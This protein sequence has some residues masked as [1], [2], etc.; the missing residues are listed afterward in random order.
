MIQ[1]ALLGI[2]LFPLLGAIANGVFGGKAGRSVVHAIA[3]L[4]VACSF[5]LACWSFSHLLQL[6]MAGHEHAALSY[7]A[8]EWF[9]ISLA[10]R[11]VPINV[12]FVMDS[13]SGVMTLV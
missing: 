8:Y 7:T 13:L 1:K 4:S 2:V 11:T 9:S 12:R 10:K 3:V 5:G 6:R